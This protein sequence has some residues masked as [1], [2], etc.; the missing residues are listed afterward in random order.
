M[1]FADIETLDDDGIDR[2]TGLQRNKLIYNPGYAGRSPIDKP[3]Y[4]K[5]KAPQ[6]KHYATASNTYGL[7]L[8]SSMSRAVQNCPKPS[9][10]CG[11]GISDPLSATCIWQMSTI[12]GT[13]Q[14]LRCNRLS[15]NQCGEN[16]AKALVFLTQDWT[17][18]TEDDLSVDTIAEFSGHSVWHTLA[19]AARGVS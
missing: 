6:C 19:K 17:P 4:L 9:T 13:K 11:I 16:A 12:A 5:V 2:R 14:M 7:T 3:E 8:V 1:V 15:R 10:P 18:V